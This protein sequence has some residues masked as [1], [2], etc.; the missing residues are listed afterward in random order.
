MRNVR[1]FVDGEYITSLKKS[2]R[3][4]EEISAW[5]KLSGAVAQVLE[6]A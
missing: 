5:R 2:R 3:L 1:A 4:E 6:S